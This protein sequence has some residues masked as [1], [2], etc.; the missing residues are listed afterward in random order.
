MP[1]ST[2]QDVQGVHSCCLLLGLDVTVQGACGKI[3]K[4]LEFFEKNFAVSLLGVFA[5]Y[6]PKHNGSIS[7]EFLPE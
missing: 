3:K 1:S 5:L 6:R 4:K 7:R 2:Q